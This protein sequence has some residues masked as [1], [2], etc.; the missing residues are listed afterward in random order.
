MKII[1][2]MAILVNYS[3]GV[4]ESTTKL[5]CVDFAKDDCSSVPNYACSWDYD[6]ISCT[7][8]TGYTRRFCV[9]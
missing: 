6:K 1:L 7:N 8:S 4:C 3:L 9:D 5:A 2:I